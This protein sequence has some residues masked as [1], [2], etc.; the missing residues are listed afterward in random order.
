MPPPPTEPQLAWRA[1]RDEVRAQAR[2]LG[3][4]VGL[5]WAIHIVNVVLF[6]GR[7]VALGIRPRSLSGLLGIVFAPFLHGGFGHLAANTLPLFMLGALVMTRRK[8]DLLVVSAFS[9]LVGG[10]GTW[11]IAPA[12]SVHVGASILIFGYLGF[13]L[14]RGVFER[15]LW[16]LLGSALVFLVYGGAL[17]GVLPGQIGISWQGHLF[18]L[19][20]GVLAA[21][22]MHRPDEAPALAP[23]KTRIAAPRARFEEARAPDAEPETI[24]EELESLRRRR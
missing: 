18:G 14:L 10:L 19:L 20:G 12:M 7:L 8:S 2:I 11:L 4:F 22:L 15:K 21:R 5:L 16:S 3:G 17:W 1:L 23:G 9:G 6:G 24:E 13:L